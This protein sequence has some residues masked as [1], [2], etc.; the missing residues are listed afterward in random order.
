MVRKR[1]S[2]FTLM[3]AL[4]TLT[5]VGVLA[6]IA[7]PQYSAYVVRGQRASAKTALLQA[8]QY[9]ERNYTTYG[10]YNYITPADCVAQPGASTV[11]LPITSA[12]S[13]GPAA[14]TITAAPLAQSF[15][16][17]ATP[18]GS[19]TCPAGSKTT[20]ADPDCGAL[21]LDNTGAQTAA[22]AA[23]TVT[24]WQR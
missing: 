11:V 20:F 21:T 15:V 10:C 18:C 24:C 8:A 6:A 12:P 5:L 22:V 17:T 13:D 23:N 7:I 9:L 1:S 2:G 3:E 16:V 4:I 14:Y 19:T